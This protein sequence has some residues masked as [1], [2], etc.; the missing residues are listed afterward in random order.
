VA[1]A[2]VELRGERAVRSGD[3]LV[4]TYEVHNRT[5]R[6]IW[7][8]EGLF[9]TGPTGSVRLAPEKA[10]VDISGGTVGVSRMLHPTP[11]N[12]LVESPEVPAAS[13]VD[14]GQK[15]SRRVVL[16]LPVTESLPYASGPG[17]TLPLEG[18][19]ELR[20]RVGYLP[21]SPDLRLYDATDSDGAAY[22][23]PGYG[24]AQQAQKVLERPVS[25]VP[26]TGPGTK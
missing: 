24:P 7:L 3:S 20:L 1:E 6:A 22:R 18:V 14:A 21:D 8:L 10:Y 2:D 26:G 13:R 4:L 25:I 11:D 15:V 16:P 19:R 23:T 5:A 17:E 9:D 12:M